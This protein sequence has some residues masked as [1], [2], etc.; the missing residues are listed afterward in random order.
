MKCT[1]CGNEV[2]LRSEHCHVCG[3]KVVVDFDVLAQSVH[4]DAAVRRSEQIAGALRWVI[5]ALLIIGALIYSINDLY[6]KPLVYDGAGLPA[7]TAPGNLQI[8]LPSLQKPYAEPRPNPSLP[9][10][11]TTAFGYRYS[12]IKEKIRE[13]SNGNKPAAG[14]TRSVPTA[15]NDGLK[16]LAQWQNAD[17][18][19]T[20]AWLPRDSDQ[21]KCRE[22]AWG[23]VGISSLAL[24]AFLGE[25]ETWIKDEKTQRS[26]PYADKLRKGLRWLASQQDKEGRFGYGEGEAVHFMYNHGMATLCMCEAAGLSGD[27]QLRE[28][29]QK[30]LD[31]L[32]KT[33]TPAGGWN[34]RATPDGDTDT[35]LS[36][37]AVQALLAGREAGLK[38]PEEALK[39]CS[40][41][42]SKAVTADGRVIYSMSSGD[43]KVD[44]PSLA[45]A[46]LMLRQLTGEDPKSPQLRQIANRLREMLPQSRKEWSPPGGWKP[47]PR[48]DDEARATFDPYKLY[49]CTYGMY[50]MGGKDWELW[51]EA[52]KKSACEMQ[53][54]KDGAWRTNDPWSLCGGNIYS[55]ALMILTLQVYYRIQ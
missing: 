7:I 46:A 15:I 50:M 34:Y 31:F 38:V 19:W 14:I 40:D 11:R 13:A 36:T 51:H 39:K 54:L 18:V 6:D 8:E 53:E 49:F 21:Y 26:G 22:Y 12:P 24:L 47:N 25:G 16:F 4:E 28:I 9:Q 17:G 41:L 45:G 2:Q 55:T 3:Q 42:Y 37:W 43:D 10:S 1:N 52:L 48:N 32:L 33:Q 23:N 27:D 35:S 30:G 20:A 29:A 5:L 44:R